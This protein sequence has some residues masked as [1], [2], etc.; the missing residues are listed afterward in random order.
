MHTTP[1]TQQYYKGINIS[2]WQ[3]QIDATAVQNDGIKL[4][5][6]RATEGATYQDPKFE[7]Y[8]NIFHNT[9]VKQAAYHNFRALSS[10]PEEQLQNINT[11]LQAVNFDLDSDML[12]LSL[13]PAG[14]KNATPDQMADTLNRLLELLKKEGYKNIYINTNNNE[15]NTHVNSH[16]HNFGEYKLWISHWVNTDSPQIPSTWTD[17][18][19]WQYTCNGS[20][21]GIVSE[22]CIDYIKSN[23]IA[24]I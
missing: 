9:T 3:G 20:V 23:D 1:K 7:Q 18:N 11:K 10:T 4:V 21:E 22:V 24:S 19:W 6:I 2:K 16:K 8:W 14:N 5:I 15:W 12:A 17:W 13:P